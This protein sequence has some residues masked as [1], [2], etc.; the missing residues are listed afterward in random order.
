MTEGY[1]ISREIGRE[2]GVGKLPFILR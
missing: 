1:K 2:S